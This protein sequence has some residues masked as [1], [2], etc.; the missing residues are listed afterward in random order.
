[1]KTKN[2]LSHSPNMFGYNT[3]KQAQAD[4][5]FSPIFRVLDNRMPVD[6]RAEDPRLLLKSHLQR[7]VKASPLC[8]A[9][10]GWLCEVQTDPFIADIQRSPNG[11]I[12]IRLSGER[13][14]EPFCSF[15]EF[16][17]QIRVICESLRMPPAQ[18]MQIV[19]LA[20][21]WLG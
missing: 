6:L 7:G 12:L 13:S 3:A 17:D 16:L 20:R 4:D 11:Q 5:C 21:Q 8:L 15:L 9:V 14:L 19:A 2:C 10:I 18:T 1:M